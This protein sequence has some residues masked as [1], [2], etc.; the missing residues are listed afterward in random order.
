MNVPENRPFVFCTEIWQL[1]FCF[2][3]KNYSQRKFTSYNMLKNH[4]EIINSCL[5]NKAKNVL[6]RSKKNFKVI[7][8]R[9][10]IKKCLDR[11]YSFD[12]PLFLF[13]PGLGTAFFSVPYVPFFSF[14]VRSLKGTF[15]SF[16]FFFWVFGDLWDPKERSV[17]F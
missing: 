15:R 1:Y 13:I 12:F 14:L 10:N 16:P 4:N 5:L 3:P 6:F 9:H 2:Y 7:W 11:T 17:L 8:K